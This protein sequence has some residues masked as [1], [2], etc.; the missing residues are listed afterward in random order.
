MQENESE[1]DAVGS[2]TC[3][4]GWLD[5]HIMDRIG[6]GRT[7]MRSLNINTDIDINVYQY[8]RLVCLT[9]LFVCHVRFIGHEEEGR[10]S[11]HEWEHLVKG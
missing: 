4:I 5:I 10:R 1:R 3:H 11:E 6:Q 9:H 2:V 7:A 8:Y